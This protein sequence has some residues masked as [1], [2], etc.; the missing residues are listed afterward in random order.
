MILQ[1]DIIISPQQ[2]P[3][4]SPMYVVQF[5]LLAGPV[6]RFK[7]LVDHLSSILQSST[8]QRYAFVFCYR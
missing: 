5:T 2:L 6:R 1:V 7:R 8:Q 4:E 3:G